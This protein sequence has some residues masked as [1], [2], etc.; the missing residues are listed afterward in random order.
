V[1]TKSRSRRAAIQSR[2]TNVADIDPE[3][4]GRRRSCLHRPAHEPPLRMH[5]GA[6]T[7]ASVESST[8]IVGSSPA[9]RSMA[10][11]WATGGSSTAGQW[12]TANGSPLAHTTDLVKVASEIE[13]WERGVPRQRTMTVANFHK[14]VMVSRVDRR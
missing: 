6:T 8:A 5:G 10:R 9:A 7:P 13:I 11:V 14:M 1:V 12:H 2:C 3:S 4:I